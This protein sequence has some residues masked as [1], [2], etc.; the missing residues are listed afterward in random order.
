LYFPSLFVF[1]QIP[2]LHLFRRPV[3][4]CY[5]WFDDVGQLDVPLL[6]TLLTKWFC[7]SRHCRH[8]LHGRFTPFP[9]LFFC[10]FPNSSFPL[11]MLCFGNGHRFVPSAN[12]ASL[13]P[14]QLTRPPFGNIIIFEGILSLDQDFA[15]FKYIILPIDDATIG[16]RSA[17]S[18]W[19]EAPMLERNFKARHRSD[20]FEYS[21]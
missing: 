16:E 4:A 9:P 6:S 15:D 13:R 19:N 8:C 17:F 14:P 1:F 18:C 11:A 12:I 20:K 21:G 2:M 5:R 10:S 7:W 3:S